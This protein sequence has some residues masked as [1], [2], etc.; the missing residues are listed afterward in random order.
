MAAET[1]NQ[2]SATTAPPMDGGVGPAAFGAGSANVQQASPQ[3]QTYRP[4]PSPP[5]AQPVDMNMCQTMMMSWIMKQIMKAENPQ[6]HDE[7]YGGEELDGLRC[8]R[9]LSKVRAVRACHE[10]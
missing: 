4:P 2:M 10:R 5:Q 1:M 9:A 8:V 3:G 7:V 6:G